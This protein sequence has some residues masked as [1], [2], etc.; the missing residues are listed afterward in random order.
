MLRLKVKENLDVLGLAQRLGKKA[1]YVARRLALTDLI[2]EAREDFL[3][4]RITLGHVLEICRLTPE[5]QADAI[6]VCYESKI[7]I[8]RKSGV[9]SYVP[10][11]DSPAHDVGYLKEWLQVKV[12]LNL[13]NYVELKIKSE[14]DNCICQR[15]AEM[16]R[17][18][19]VSGLV[20]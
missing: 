18:T 14:G 11:K 16:A 3:L 13:Q 4:G 9:S 20:L 15:L 5:V 8:D 10:D 17:R 2:D 6:A 1:R 7:V 19:L 12:Y